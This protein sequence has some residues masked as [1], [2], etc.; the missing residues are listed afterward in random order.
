MYLVINQHDKKNATK[1]KTAI[2][3]ILQNKIL[4]IFK[5]LKLYR[6]NVKN[7]H[8]TLIYSIHLTN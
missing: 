3:I 7:L 8:K 4:I 6:T 2:I 1:H 5:T